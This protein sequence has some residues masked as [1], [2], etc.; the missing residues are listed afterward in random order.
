MTL[1]N[2]LI[3]P[4]GHALTAGKLYL[5]LYH[6][7]KNPAEE[8]DDWGFAGPTFGPLTCVVQ[9]YFTT[10]RLLDPDGGELWL[11]QFDD[12]VVWEDCYYGDL[13]IFVA[14]ASDA[15]EV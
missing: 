15:A 7:R 6:G 1:S 9:T 2:K 8:M 10:L 4:S 5:H 14:E 12:L 11:E 13:S 3:V